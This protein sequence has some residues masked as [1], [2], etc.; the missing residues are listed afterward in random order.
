MVEMPFA[1]AKTHSQLAANSLRNR[2]QVD[3]FLQRGVRFSVCIEGGLMDG[4]SSQLYA[5]SCTIGASLRSDIVLF[6][7][8]IEDNHIE[9]TF[10]SSIFGPVL[11]VRALASGV[12][13]AN[14]P[15]E[16]G[17]VSK[18]QALPLVINVNNIPLTIEPQQNS[19][20]TYNPIIV[21]TWHYS[22]YPILAVSILLLAV[23]LM[24]GPNFNFEVAM[25]QDPLPYNI[26]QR[27]ESELQRLQIAATS[28]QEKLDELELAEY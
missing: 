28:V 13:V 3:R 24:N 6:D 27:R 11:S 15:L 26:V 20:R 10:K 2:S 1:D 18:Y 14:E 8:G 22:R 5:R 9:L 19:G 21:Q 12:E 23:Q 25:T 4:L 16:R 7:E 17:K